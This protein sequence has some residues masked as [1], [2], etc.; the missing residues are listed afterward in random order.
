VR[1]SNYEHASRDQWGAA[2]E[3]WKRAAEKPDTGATKAAA[4]WLLESVALSSGDRVLE[5]ACGAGRVGLQAADQVGADG[6]V[7]CSDFAE[8]MVDVVRA[9]IADLELENVEAR[10]LNAENLGE[11]DPDEPFDAVLCRTGYMLMA[12]PGAALGESYR[13]LKSGGRLGCA[14]WGPA[15]KNPWLSIVFDAVMSRLKAPPP[16]P[17]MP[18]PFALSDATE[19]RRMVKAAGFNSVDVEAIAPTQEYESLADW[20]EQVTEIGGPLSS[21]LNALPPED[22]EAIQDDALRRAAG[23]VNSEGASF[24]ASMLCVSGRRD[25]SGS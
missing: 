18:G 25:A 10:V 9:R 15:D 21:V 19:L 22:A 1:V 13:V 23:F 12:D 2:A 16:E 14:V 24:P 11:L 8:A 5:L 20:W 17:G 3:K 6:Y 7:L 4:D